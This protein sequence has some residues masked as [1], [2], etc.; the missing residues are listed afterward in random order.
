MAQLAFQQIVSDAPGGQGQDLRAH[1][2][3][4]VCLLGRYMLPDRPEYP[5]QTRDL[6]LGGVALYAP[7]QG[8]P[9]DRVVLHLDRIGRL[10]GEVARTFRSGFAVA[11]ALPQ[12]WREKLVDELGWLTNGA[13][14]DLSE[15]QPKRGSGARRRAELRLVTGDEFRVDVLDATLSGVALAFEFKLPL[16]TRLTVG[17]TPGRVVRNFDGGVAIEFLKRVDRGPDGA[18][19]F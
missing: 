10:E 6:S 17:R 11:F 7:V 18:V 12:V 14:L 5:C 19:A 15:T 3:T 16:G 13:A 1:A 8:V 4:P 2:R 9:G